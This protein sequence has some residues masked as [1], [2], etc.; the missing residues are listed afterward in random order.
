ME[1][2]EK[3]LVNMDIGF[4]ERKKEYNIIDTERSKTPTDPPPSDDILTPDGLPTIKEQLRRMAEEDAK[5]EAINNTV[6]NREKLKRK[7]MITIIKTICL[8]KMNKPPLTNTNTLTLNQKKALIDAMNTYAKR[9]EEEVKKEF[10][11]IC[12][13]HIFSNPKINYNDLPI[14]N[15]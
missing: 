5:M 12:E 7:E 14:Y 13:E 2:I 3:E 10:A 15:I 1:E 11:D 8:V 4:E 6:E 9:S